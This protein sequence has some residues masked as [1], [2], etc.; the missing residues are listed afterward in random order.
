V[1]G[2]KIIRKCIKLLV[3]CSL[4]VMLGG[5]IGHVKQLPLVESEVRAAI[6]TPY[7]QQYIELSKKRPGRKRTIKYIVIHNTANSTSTAQN[8]VDYLSN[9]NNTSSTSF[10][11]AVDEHEIIEAIPVTEVAYHAGDRV[12]NQYG[13]GIEICESGDFQQTKAH[14]AKLVA[15]LMKCY[16]IPLSNVKAHKDFSGKDCPR[17]MLDN[18]DAFL[19]QIQE[20]YQNLPK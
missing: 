16:D 14:A 20:A 7:S 11:L 3:V 18:W 15:Y 12:G 8:E 5:F 19:E 13:I 1:K 2:L 17:L 4:M 9:P 10:H 6:G